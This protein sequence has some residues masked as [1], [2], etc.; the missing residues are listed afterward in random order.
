MLIKQ[1]NATNGKNEENLHQLRR[2]YPSKND[3]LNR[4]LT[5]G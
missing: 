3:V 1:S 5:E 4:I 2:I